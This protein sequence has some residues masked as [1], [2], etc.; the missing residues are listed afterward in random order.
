MQPG[1]DGIELMENGP[2][3]SDMPVILLHAYS[4]EQMVSRVLE[5]GTEDYI[6]KSFSPTELV[7]RIQTVL[8]IRK[9]A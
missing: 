3:L 5:A 9:G 1:A 7:A 8:S 2:E 6:V 4:W